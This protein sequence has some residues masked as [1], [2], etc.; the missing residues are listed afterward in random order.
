M[1]KEIRCRIAPDSNF[2]KMFPAHESAVAFVAVAVKPL[3]GAR[4]QG[5]A[6]SIGQLPLGSLESLRDHGLLVNKII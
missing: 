1:V 4:L 6:E 2:D 3:L 5:D